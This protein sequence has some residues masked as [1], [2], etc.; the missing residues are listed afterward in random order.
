MQILS[1]KNYLLSAFF[2]HFLSI[3]AALKQHFY[4]TATKN[5]PLIGGLL[6]VAHCD[7][8]SHS[9]SR[10]RRLDSFTILS[11]RS[12]I[13]CPGCGHGSS[14][15]V[16]FIIFVVFGV[17]YYIATFVPWFMASCRCRRFSFVLARLILNTVPRLLFFTEGSLRLYLRHIG[18]AENLDNNYERRCDSG[19]YLQGLFFHSI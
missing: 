18:F 8:F 17:L 10:S 14:N 15:T 7:Y 1:S 5:L 3:Y 11:M 12:C 19:K 13:L 16:T 6:Y 2:F 4:F 9:F